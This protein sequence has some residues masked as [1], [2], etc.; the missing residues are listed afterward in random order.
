MQS[1]IET[2]PLILSHAD[3]ARHGIR[4]TRAP[5]P[6]LVREGELTSPVEIAAS[7][8]AFLFSDIVAFLERRRALAPAD[9]MRR[10]QQG[11]AATAVRIPNPERWTASRAKAAAS[12]KRNLAALNAALEAIAKELLA[13]D[14]AAAK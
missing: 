12:R 1:K 8:V 14:G 2:M 13:A 7:R 9:F 6:R 4:L 5:I 11:Q 10:Q 3:L